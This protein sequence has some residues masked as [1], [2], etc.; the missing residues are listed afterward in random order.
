MRKRS[1]S[2]KGHRTSV[3]LEETFWESLEAFA[4]EDHRSLP[5]LIAEVD[6]RRL[7]DPEN[8]GLASALRVYAHSRMKS[9]TDDGLAVGDQPE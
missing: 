3:C 2:L 9:R 1:L 6:R 7:D 5:A 4:R 8:P